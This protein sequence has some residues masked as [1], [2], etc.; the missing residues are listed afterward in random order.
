MRETGLRFKWFCWL[1]VGTVLLS[2]CQVTLIGAFGYDV[3]CIE[4]VSD[5]MGEEEAEDSENEEESKKRHDD[6]PS[7]SEL[8][9]SNLEKLKV[10]HKDTR[11]HSVFREVFSPPPELS[12]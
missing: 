8:A 5:S 4:F 11:Y 9:N 10:L 6:S 2:S 7:V 3:S 12:I 1:F